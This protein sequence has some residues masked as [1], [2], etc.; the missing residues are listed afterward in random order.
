[1]TWMQCWN[2]K[3]GVKITQLLYSIDSWVGYKVE[4]DTLWPPSALL[5]TDLYLNLNP[6][7]RLIG[8]A[9]E[10]VGKVEGQNLKTLLHSGAQISQLTKPI[11]KPLGLKI[12][13][14]RC[15]RN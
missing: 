9:T 11:V 3:K 6:S 7:E 13:I 2:L 1:M 14:R 12:T 15:S 4:V 10:T 8:K 5:Q